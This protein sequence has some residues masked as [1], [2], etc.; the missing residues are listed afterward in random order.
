MLLYVETIH[1]S[2]SGTVSSGVSQGG[3]PTTTIGPFE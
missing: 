1:L 3:K 2:V